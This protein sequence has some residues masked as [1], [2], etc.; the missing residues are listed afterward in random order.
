MPAAYRE[1]TRTYGT[2][3]VRSISG[4]SAQSAAING[5]E[6]VMLY[7]GDT[8]ICFFKTGANPIADLTTSI[9]L[10]PGERLHVQIS[11]GDKVAVIGT[12]GNLYITPAN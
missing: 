11:Q 7:N 12:S 1:G 2:T 4:A 3:Q 9:P 8:S 5:A 6:E 10:G